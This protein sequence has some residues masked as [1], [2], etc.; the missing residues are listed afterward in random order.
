M[1]TACRIDKVPVRTYGWLNRSV[2]GSL[3]FEY[4]P[5]LVMPRQRQALPQGHCFVGR[6]FFHPV[7]FREQGNESSPVLILPPR[8]RTHE[9]EVSDVYGF[10]GVR[11]VGLR[12][13]F[14]AFLELLGIGTRQLAPAS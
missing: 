3:R 4:R 5:W 7:V 11:D 2:D 12:R 8:Y 6:G 1:F 10:A 9:Q 14:K 13:F